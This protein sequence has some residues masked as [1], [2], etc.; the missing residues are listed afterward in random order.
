MNSDDVVYLSLLFFSIGFGV[1]YRKLPTAEYKQNVGA[2]LGL[3]IVFLVSGFHSLHFLFIIVVNSLII[4]SVDKGKC[5][6]YSFLFSFS[7]LCFFRMSGYFGMAFP[8]GHTNLVQMILT[9]KLVGLAFELNSGDIDYSQLSIRKIFYYSFNYCGILTG[10]YFKYKTFI[11]HL[12]CP[13][14]KYD[15]YKSATL[16]R[17]FPYVPLYAIIFLIFDS[18]WPMTYTLTV[19]FYQRSFLYRYWYIWPTFTI[20]RMR[21]YVG[22]VLSECSCIMAGLGIYPTFTKPKP[23]KGPSDNIEKLKEI[24]V[25]E[26]ALETLEY[27]YETINN[28]NPYIT[29]FCPT[30]REGIKNW[31]MTV[32]YWLGVYVYKHFPYKQFRTFATLFVSSIWHGITP[33]HYF[34]ICTVPLGLLVE[35]IWVKLLIKD[36]SI[37]PARTASLILWFLKMQLFSYQIMAFNMLDLQKFMT[38]YNSVYHCVPV[39]CFA[40]YSTGIYLL[41]NRNTNTKEF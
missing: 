11:D 38:Y 37:I 25:D 31:N 22:L 24:C 19:E 40:L 21:I 7:Y 20:F 34:C 1:F 23:G 15:N 18:T 8:S 9:L 3:I 26:R 13:F 12:Y 36:N 17:L 16:K 14:N 5:H 30:Y 35:D 2:I 33:G 4:Y 6:V 39:L 29:E 32:Q 10:P 41:K 27:D 28:I